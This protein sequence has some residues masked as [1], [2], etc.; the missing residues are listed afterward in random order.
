MTSLFFRDVERQA[1]RMGDMIQRLDVDTLKLVCLRG[2]GA[3]VRARTTCLDCSNTARCLQWLDAPLS[4][5]A[6]PTF[7]PNLSLLEECTR[8]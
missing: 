4:D 7:C 2:G 6:R 5:G 1:R 3:Y 8:E